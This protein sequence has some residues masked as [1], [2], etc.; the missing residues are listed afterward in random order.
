MHSPCFGGTT[1]QGRG[2]LAAKKPL[3]DSRAKNFPK[4]RAS[5]DILLMPHFCLSHP[6]VYVAIYSDDTIGLSNLSVTILILSFLLTGDWKEVQ[7]LELTSWRI[8]AWY[9]HCAICLLNT[10][11]S[12]TSWNIQDCRWLEVQSTRSRWDVAQLQRLLGQNALPHDSKT[13]LEQ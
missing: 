6:W 2:E 9:M 8:K 12:F 1:C 5:H 13:C 7:W 4:T 3:K 10:T 11:R